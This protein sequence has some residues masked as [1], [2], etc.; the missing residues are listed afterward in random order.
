MALEANR[1]RWAFRKNNNPPTK[2]QSVSM[3]SI[4]DCEDPHRV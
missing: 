1:E 2:Q 3:H 4:T